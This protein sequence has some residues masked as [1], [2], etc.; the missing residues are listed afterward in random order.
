MNNY[1]HI[2]NKISTSFKSKEQQKLAS[3]L[4]DKA[5]IWIAEQNENGKPL[6]RQDLEK[7]LWINCSVNE[8]ELSI[9]SFFY[10]II[11]KIIIRW[12]IEEI[13]RGTK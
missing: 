3:H 1:T 5:K 7:Y 10:W 8:K 12:I 13:F 4:L 11:M 2:S 6:S 9:S